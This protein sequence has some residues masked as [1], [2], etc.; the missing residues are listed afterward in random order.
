MHAVSEMGGP[1]KGTPGTQRFAHGLGVGDLNGD[2]RADVICTAGWWEQPESAR[3]TTKAL[4]LPPRA[5]SR[6]RRRPT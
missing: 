1:D 5:S 4:G 6:R 2:G 3:K